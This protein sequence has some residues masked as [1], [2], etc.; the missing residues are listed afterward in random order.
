MKRGPE[1]HLRTFRQRH[2]EQRDGNA[3]GEQKEKVRGGKEKTKYV[4]C[5]VLL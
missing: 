1:A 4:N 3:K 5:D 2:G